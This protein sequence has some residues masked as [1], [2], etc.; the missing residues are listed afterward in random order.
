MKPG[1]YLV[2]PD[3]E[4]RFIAAGVNARALERLCD[5][6]LSES[7]G[8]AYWIDYC[9]GPDVFGAPAWSNL[10]QTDRFI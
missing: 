5:R 9:C 6:H 7:T 1:F 10:D 3:G 2:T 4:R 8:W